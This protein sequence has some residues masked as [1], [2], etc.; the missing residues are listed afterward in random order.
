MKQ[1]NRVCL[2][3]PAIGP[4]TRGRCPTH[5]RARDKARGTRQARGYD[6][7]HDREAK[8]WR[9]KVRAGELVLCWRCGLPITNPD[10]CHLGH[11]DHDRS[12]TRGPEHGRDCNL[13]AAG[14]ARHGISPDD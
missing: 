10:D 8:H 11:D 5:D 7:A 12:V 3:C 2:D 4:W 6:A 1:R 13:R 14:K 9:D